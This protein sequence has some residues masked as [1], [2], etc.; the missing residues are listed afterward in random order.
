MSKEKFNGFSQPTFYTPEEASQKK[1]A[2]EQTKRATEMHERKQVNSFLKKVRLDFLSDSSFNKAIK[3]MGV[4]AELRGEEGL[5]DT[6]DKYDFQEI[7]DVLD[8]TEKFENPIHEEEKMYN[9]LIE[10]IQKII[11]LGVTFVFK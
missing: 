7:F 4:A 9:Y 8:K 1:K 6:S 11:D 5:T 10:E 3:N 2:E